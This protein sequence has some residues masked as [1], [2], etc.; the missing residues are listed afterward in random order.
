[1]KK[2]RLL[3]ALLPLFWSCSNGDSNSP[4][5]NVLLPRQKSDYGLN[6][7]QVKISSNGL[8]YWNDK[9]LDSSSLLDSINQD[10]V[11]TVEL[12]AVPDVPYKYPSLVIRET[13]RLG[14]DIVLTYRN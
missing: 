10:H 7:D 1:M 4:Y 3:L 14:K 9:F 5:D 8:Y 2:T 6:I 13:R 12:I 11:Y